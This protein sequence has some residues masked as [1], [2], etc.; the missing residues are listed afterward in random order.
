MWLTCSGSLLANLAADDEAGFEAAEGTVAH[1]VGE[2]W[3][4]TGE[5]PDHLVGDIVEIDEGHEVFHIEITTEMLDFVQE[6]VDWCMYLPGDKFVEKRVYFSQLTPIP[7]QGGTAD[8]FALEP[9]V[10]TITDLKYGIG[11]PVSAEENTQAMLYALGVFYEWDWAYN[12]QRIVIRI[13]QPRRDNMDVWETTRDRLM[14]FAGYVKA[15]AA[16]AWVPNAPRTPSEKGCRWCKV[17]RDCPAYLTIAEDIA[18]DAFADLDEISTERM[19]RAMKR[20]DQRIEPPVLEKP[21]KLTTKQL[22][23]LSQYGSLFK[24]FFEGID[25]ELISRAQD[26]EKVPG[27]K[28]V[29][30]VSHRVFTS[31]EEAEEAVAEAG[32]DPLDLYVAKTRTPAQ[33]EEMLM[34]KRGLKKAEAVKI[35]AKAV[36]KPPGKPTLAPITDKRPELVIDVDEMF[37]D[38]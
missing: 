32:L 15:R 26:G 2:E 16:L 25:E 35:L 23:K 18:D 33:M 14:E 11:E 13:A 30:G 5:R 29:E 17:K 24:S 1:S 9:G 21:M 28:L 6:Y 27:K 10:L 19:E 37:A 8:H 34:K 20:L 36:R 31:E 38:L 7:K 22:I 3:L 12:F 4:K